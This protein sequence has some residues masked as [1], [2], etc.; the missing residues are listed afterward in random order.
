MMMIKVEVMVGVVM[1]SIDCSA[2]RIKIDY[3][4]RGTM[5]IGYLIG[6]MVMIYC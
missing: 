6:E 4:V 2:M 1:G 3:L 5:M